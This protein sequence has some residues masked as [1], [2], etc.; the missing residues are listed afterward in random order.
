[1]SLRWQMSCIYG[2]EDQVE[3]SDAERLTFVR[4]TKVVN[5]GRFT[6]KSCEDLYLAREIEA[7]DPT[8]LMRLAYRLTICKHRSQEDG[9]Q[10]KG[11]KRRDKSHEEQ[12]GRDETDDGRDGINA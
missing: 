12:S 10:G 8:I 3:K 6:L 4:S 1:M 9:S 11:R 7:R 2:G 5:I